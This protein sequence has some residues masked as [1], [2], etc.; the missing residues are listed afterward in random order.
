M[1]GGIELLLL[2]I[3]LIIIIITLNNDNCGQMTLMYI[4]TKVF[5]ILS[6][7]IF[8][9]KKKNNVFS[10][11]MKSIIFFHYLVGKKVPFK[12]AFMSFKSKT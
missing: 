1:S 5:M 3:I 6:F 12:V 8:I 2:I 11:S 9:C 4:W 7:Q 10:I